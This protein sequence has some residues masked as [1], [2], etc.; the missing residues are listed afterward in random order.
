M[1]YLIL[2]FSLMAYSSWMFINSFTTKRPLEKPSKVLFG[3]FFTVGAGMALF[4]LQKASPK[5]LSAI[6]QYLQEYPNLITIIQDKNPVIY[7][8]EYLEIIEAYKELKD[9]DGF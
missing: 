8:Y 5:D 6:H 4:A 3:I 2:A 1:L 7:K 9:E